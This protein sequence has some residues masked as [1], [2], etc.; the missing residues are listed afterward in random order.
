MLIDT[1]TDT[2]AEFGGLDRELGLAFC[3]TFSYLG[4]QLRFRFLM[5]LWVQSCMPYRYGLH[6]SH[7]SLR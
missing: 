4:L 5:D 2:M 3:F 1:D 7:V 6:M